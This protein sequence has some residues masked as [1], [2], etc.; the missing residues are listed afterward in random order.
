MPSRQEMAEI[1]DPRAS[2]PKTFVVEVHEGGRSSS[3][4]LTALWPGGQVEETDDGYLQILHTDAGDAWV[5]SLGRRFW[6]FHTL[7]PV[8]DMRSV[9]HEAIESNRW[10]DWLWLPTEQLENVWPDAEIRGLTTDFSTNGITE[11]DGLADGL[12]IRATGS[13]AGTLLRK[14]STLE[15]YKTAVSVQ[16]VQIR[17]D[18]VDYG[19]PLDEAVG[20]DGRFTAAN[21]TFQFH[22]ALVSRVVK[23][24]ASWVDGIE[25]EALSW[26]GLPNGGMLPRGGILGIRFSEPQHDVEALVEGIFS[27]RMPFR[28]WGI[29]EFHGGWAHVDAVDLH[30]GQMLTFQVAPTGVQVTIGAGVCGNTIA[31]FVSNLQHK[32]DGAV[33]M[34]A[35]HL[36]S[37]MNGDLPVSA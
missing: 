5:D 33:E 8:A 13:R 30:V 14:L 12:R 25:Q 11:S 27:S 19:E 16:G 29:P 37:L 20:R 18:S 7:A 15:E 31:R 23:R 9:L 32:V 2:R 10:M 3:E 1:M 35:P 21:G 22:E 36:Q 4:I 34:T 26:S 17:A 6:R 24:Y 28:L